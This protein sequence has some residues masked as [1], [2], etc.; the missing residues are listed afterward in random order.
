VGS[1]ARRLLNEKMQLA[2]FD[3]VHHTHP[4]YPTL[5]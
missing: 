2:V 1:E 4:F 3:L 5:L